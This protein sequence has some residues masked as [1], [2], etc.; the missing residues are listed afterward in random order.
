MGTCISGHVIWGHAGELWEADEGGV[1]DRRGRECPST[2]GHSKGYDGDGGHSGGGEDDRDDDYGDDDDAD[3]DCNDDDDE[4]TDAHSAQCRL[5]V[6]A[7]RDSL[8]RSVC[9]VF[10]TIIIMVVTIITIIS[11]ISIIITMLELVF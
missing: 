1:G 8:G 3:D 9:Q 7:P 5:K 2:Y 6:T 10:H 4:C 11:I